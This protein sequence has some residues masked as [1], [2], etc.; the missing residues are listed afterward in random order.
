MEIPDFV[1]IGRVAGPWGRD[2]QLKIDILTD[3]PERFQPGS[4]IYIDGIVQTIESASWKRGMAIIKLPAMDSVDE[5]EKLRG[6]MVEASTKDLA[7]L[8]PGQYYHFQLTGLDVV[9]TDGRPLGKISRIMAGAGNDVYVVSTPEGELLVP[10]VEDV[11]KC[12]D[13]G[14]RQVTIEAIEGLL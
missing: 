12:I 6:Q 10:A 1:V 14:R 9:T 13:L 2:G 11:V 3:F 8:P 4:T 7:P 5:A